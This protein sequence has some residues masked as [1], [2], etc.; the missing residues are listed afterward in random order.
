MAEMNPLE[1]SDEEFL[2]G[3][4]P[5][6][7]EEEPTPEPKQEE[8]VPKEDPKEPEEQEPKE[9]AIE[10]SK[11]EVTEEASTSGSK[12]EVK[13]ESK[14]EESEVREETTE[15]QIDYKA[16]YEKIMKPFK[17]NGKTIEL[18]SPEE[19]IKLMQQ[20]ANY[21]R[22]M[23]AIAPHRKLLIMLENNGLLDENKLNYLIDLE[24]HNPDAIRKLVKDSGLDAFTLD[25]SEN[26]N[27]VYK[28]NNYG[29]TDT[30]VNFQTAIEDLKSEPQG[31][32]T[33]IEINSNWD[34]ESK[35][36][37]GTQP[38]LLH[39]INEHR[40]NGIYEAVSKEVERQRMLGYIPSNMPFL[41][42]YKQVG[43]QMNEQA[44]KRTPPPVIHKQPIARGT[45]I[46]KQP[47]DLGNKDRVKAAA[48]TRG[49]NKSNKTPIV[50]PLTMSD[51]EFMKMF[52]KNRL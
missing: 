45:T 2:K 46:A 7:K 30:V 13:E 5:E 15:E 32:E 42:A 14:T 1:M 50:N 10:E 9:E 29:V 22:K 12:E 49:T 28:P 26:Q 18:K 47:M 52:D 4:P 25:P 6:V 33:L 51:E 44:N 43:N 20:G 40:Q 34:T 23:Q 38:E 11:E 3:A 35:N 21:T 17:A 27:E 24:K 39:I 41:E 36:I 31:M 8:P 16:E 48:P 37:L 19:V